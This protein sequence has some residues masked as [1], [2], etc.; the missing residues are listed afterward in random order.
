MN[1]ELIV[2]DMAGTTV[3]DQHEVEACFAQAAR[4]TG[5]RVSDEAILAAQ[6]LAKRFVFQQFWRS[7]LGQ[8]HPEVEANVDVSYAVFKE[9]LENHYQTQPVF[10]TEGCLETFAWL[11]QQNI[12]VALTTGFYRVVT[13]IIL[14]RLGWLDGLDENRVGNQNTLIQASIASDEVPAGRPQPFMIQK[15]MHLLGVSDPQRVVNLGDTPSDLQ[16]GA[17]AGVLCNIGLVNGTHSEAQLEPHPHHV[18][19]ASLK[20]LP[21][22]LQTTYGALLSPKTDWQMA[23]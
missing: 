16:S 10:P 6:G 4:Q 13:D 5:L 22:F 17:A 12:K 11:R 21:A 2:F 8:N 15:A 19:L 18:L 1:I 9:I 23:K 20:D 14:E 7:Q 3:A